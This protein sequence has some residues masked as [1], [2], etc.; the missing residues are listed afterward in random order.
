L[1]ENQQF[2]YLQAV[3]QKPPS[4][5]PNH[6][7]K[8]LV[9]DDPHAK[10]VKIAGSFNNWTPTNDYLMD[11]TEDGKWSKVL[12]LAPGEYQYKFVID[13]KIWV[14]DE[15]NYRVKIDPY[16]GKNSVLVVS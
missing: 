4:L 14:E 16:Y 2:D 7:E 15:G 10:S 13:D 3:E 12:S 11:Q 9:L 8:E 6:V 1:D 5:I